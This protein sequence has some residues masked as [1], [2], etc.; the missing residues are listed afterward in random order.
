MAGREALIPV[1]MLTALLSILP[2]AHAS[3]G[4]SAGYR[5]GAVGCGA[6]I[7]ALCCGADLGGEPVAPLFEAINSVQQDRST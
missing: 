7:C 2:A 1:A 3:L 5:Q 4:V 6:G